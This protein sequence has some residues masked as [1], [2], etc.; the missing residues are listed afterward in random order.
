MIIGLILGLMAEFI[1]LH[2]ILGA[3]LAG[4]LVRQNIENDFIFKKVE[5]R[6]YGISYSFLGPIF[7][8]SVGMAISFEG[9]IQHPW[10]FLASFILVLGMQ[11]VGS[12]LAT[13]CLHPEEFDGKRA[14]AVALT[15]GGRGGTEII[16]AQIGASTL[17]SQ[18]NTPLLSPEYLSFVVLIAFFATLVIPFGLRFLLRR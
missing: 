8:V 12:G 6:L 15:L 9:I 2:I 18:S 11:V 1:G 4:M 13:R 10:L 3:Y 16:V 14:S 17:I 7:F 5:D